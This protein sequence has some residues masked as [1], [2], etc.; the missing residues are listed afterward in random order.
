MSTS[1]AVRPGHP[2][3]GRKMTPVSIALWSAIAVVGA[4]CWAVLALSRGEEV[5]A[6]WILFAALAS[7]ARA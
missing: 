3:G 4:V 6:L 1:T 5:S 7:S 2:P